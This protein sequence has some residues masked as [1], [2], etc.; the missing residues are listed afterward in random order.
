MRKE[1]SKC[2]KTKVVNREQDTEKSVG[3]LVDGSLS[4]RN[5]VG[6][7]QVIIVIKISPGFFVCLFCLFSISG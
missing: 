2:E 1:F 6:P 7:V 4:L 5:S 3:V